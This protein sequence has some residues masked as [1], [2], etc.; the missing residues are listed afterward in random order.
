M[1]RKNAQNKQVTRGGFSALHLL[2]NYA[3]IV[4][5]TLNSD[6]LS[7]EDAIN[8]PRDQRGGPAIALKDTYQPYGF[9]GL[10]IV[11]D[12]PVAPSSV[13]AHRTKPVPSAWNFYHET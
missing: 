4:S 3:T 8:W 9:S 6:L 7:Q 11:S 10:S 1:Q 2:S 12:R 13:K 5:I